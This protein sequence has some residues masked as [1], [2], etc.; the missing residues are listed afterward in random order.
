MA[1]TRIDAANRALADGETF[2]ARH[3]LRSAIE[4]IEMLEGLAPQQPSPKQ[5]GTGAVLEI[6]AT[7]KPHDH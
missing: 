7:T 2:I 4:K 6:E 5:I 1:H 3:H